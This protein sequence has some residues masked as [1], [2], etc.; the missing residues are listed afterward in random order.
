M[1]KD[2]AAPEDIEFATRYLGLNEA[3]GFN[4]GIIRGG[5]GSVAKLFVAQMQDYLN[6]GKGHRMNLPG[7]AVGN[8]QWRMMPGE[9]SEELAARIHEMLRMYG[10]LNPNIKTEEP[11]SDEDASDAEETSIQE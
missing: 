2:E 11:D 1:W 4:Y 6:L 10:R 3:E 9:A 5:M 8:W 7:T